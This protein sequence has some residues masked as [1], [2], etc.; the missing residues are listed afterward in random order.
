VLKPGAVSAAQQS[1]AI[2]L[3]VH[4]DARPG[5]RAASWDRFLVPRAFAQVRIAYGAAVAVGPGSPG[6]SEAASRCV[7]ELE[8]AARMAAWPDGAGTRTA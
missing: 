8:N 5:W 2:L 1:G 6:L 3:P 4:A 7:R